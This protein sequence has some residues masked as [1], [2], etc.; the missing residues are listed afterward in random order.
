MARRASPYASRSLQCRRHSPFDI[1]TKLGREG[2]ESRAGCHCPTRPHHDIGQIARPVAE[3]FPWE[4]PG[5]CRPAF[6][7]PFSRL[8]LVTPRLRR[9]RGLETPLLCAAT[10]TGRRRGEGGDPHADAHG[11]YPERPQQ[12]ERRE[13]LRQ[14]RL[15]VAACL[16]VAF[17]R[18]CLVSPRLRRARG[19][20]TRSNQ[21]ESQVGAACRA[22]AFGCSA[23]DVPAGTPQ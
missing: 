7:W 12:I 8:C 18:L 13:A 9:A 19:P 4:R 14:E 10:S 23:T 15:A 6:R 16:S 17:G 22:R 5:G 11:A 3:A 1:A 2:V 20:E 21:A